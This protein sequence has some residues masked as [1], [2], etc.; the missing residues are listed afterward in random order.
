[1]LTFIYEIEKKEYNE[2]EIDSHKK[3]LSRTKSKNN[4]LLHSIVFKISALELYLRHPTLSL[5]WRR[6]EKTPKSY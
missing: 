3:N 2:T 1:M 4:S 5:T 6:F